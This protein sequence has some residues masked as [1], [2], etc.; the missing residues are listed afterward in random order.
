MKTLL[1]GR[2][3]KSDRY[4]GLGMR[5]RDRTLNE[6]GNRDA[7]KLGQALKNY[8]FMPDRVIS[9]PA[10]RAFE[11]ARIVTSHAGFVGEIQTDERIYTGGLP[12]ILSCLQ[13]TEPEINHLACFGHNPTVSELIQY[14]AR[15]DIEP[16]TPTG[17]LALIQF[18]TVSWEQIGKCR[19]E[20]IFLLIP[21]LI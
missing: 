14:F 13:E 16:K 9:S 15:M 12:G 5:D 1:I 20:L 18:H 2:H 19:A 10:I 7:P 6:R 11:T 21:K 4:L 3:A 8:E 17:T